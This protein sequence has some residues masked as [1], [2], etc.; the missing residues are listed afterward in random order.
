MAV[1]RCGGLPDF[2]SVAPAEQIQR[3]A[4]GGQQASNDPKPAQIHG[5]FEAAAQKRGMIRSEA[6]NIMVSQ[7]PQDVL[8]RY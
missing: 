5:S 3:T 8:M 6:L 2:F 1:C 4:T 7:R